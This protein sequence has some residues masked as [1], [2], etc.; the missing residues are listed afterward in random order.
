[1]S[2]HHLTESDVGGVVVV[3]GMLFGQISNVN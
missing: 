1:M 3:V 2:K